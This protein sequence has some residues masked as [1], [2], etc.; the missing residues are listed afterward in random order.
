[1]ANDELRLH[2][3][4]VRLVSQRLDDDP[5]PLPAATVRHAIADLKLVIRDVAC[6]AVAHFERTTGFT[7]SH[8]DIDMVDATVHDHGPRFY[9]VGAIRLRFDESL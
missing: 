7:P 5:A 4:P 9:I 3:A 8:I 6:E 1:M 2:L